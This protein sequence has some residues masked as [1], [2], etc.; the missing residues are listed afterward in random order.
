[1]IL[2]VEGSNKVGKTTFINS[3]VEK[4]N[5]FNNIEVEIFNDRPAIDNAKEVTKEMMYKVTRDDFIKA[6]KKSLDNVN[7]N[8]IC[9][10]DRS[11]IS[12]YVYGNIYRNYKNEDVL[13]LDKFI[14]DIPFVKQLFLMSNYSHIEDNEL[15]LKYSRIQYDMIYEV[16]KCKSSFTVK[17]IE[18]E[19]AAEELATAYAERIEAEMK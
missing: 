6:L 4:L 12:E 11:Y 7:K 2:I 18:N 10:F 8:Y 14:A 5:R 15:K 3:L 16:M 19:N 1:M 9:I 13:K 17:W